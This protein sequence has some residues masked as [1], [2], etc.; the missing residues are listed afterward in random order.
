MTWKSKLWPVLGWYWIKQHV[1]TIPKTI[2]EHRYK[3]I[4]NYSPKFKEMVI[5]GAKFWLKT[6]IF[7]QLDIKLSSSC[8]KSTETWYIIITKP[9]ELKILSISLK[10]IHPSKFLCLPTFR[11]TTSQFSSFFRLKTS[12]KLFLSKVLIM[13]L[14]NY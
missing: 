4:L 10:I 6:W 7:F 12:K 5:F 1:W 8:R 14:L 11:Q 9:C 2:M 13:N 3:I